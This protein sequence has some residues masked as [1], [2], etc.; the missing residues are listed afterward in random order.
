MFPDGHPDSFMDIIFNAMDKRRIG[1]V[2]FRD[3]VKTISITVSGSADDKLN[4]AF[5]VFDQKG[6]GV[7]TLDEMINVVEAL[8]QLHGES[9]DMEDY[10]LQFIRRRTRR[11]F[12]RLDVKRTGFVSRDQFREVLKQDEWI[13]KN[14]LHVYSSAMG[15]FSRVVETN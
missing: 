12:R 5:D 15:A 8:W 3:F 11:I 4:W 7:V 14:V 13:V 10:K 2:T 6:D 9:P 1:Y